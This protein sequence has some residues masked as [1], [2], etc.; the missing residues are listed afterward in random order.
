MADS[1]VDN[2]HQTAS[3]NILSDSDLHNARFP[4]IITVTHIAS[5]TAGT[6]YAAAAAVAVCV[7]CGKYWCISFEYISRRIAIVWATDRASD[8]GRESIEVMED[9]RERDRANWTETP[10]Q[11]PS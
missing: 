10:T 2:F 7:Q 1:N 6:E 4:Y 5:N 3:H 9:E 8:R 11:V